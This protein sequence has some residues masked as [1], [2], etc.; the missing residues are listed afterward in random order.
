MQALHGA[1]GVGKTTLAVEYAHRFGEDYDVV[2]WVPAEDSTLIADRLADLA[3]T[4]GLAAA[5][6]PVPTALSRLLGELRHRERW[7]LIFDNAEDP[8]ALAPFLPGGAGHVLITSRDPGWRAVA[9]PQPIE[10]FDRA[11]SVDLLQSQVP[12]L[13]A[14][15]ADQLADAL[16]HLPLALAQAAAFMDETSTSAESYLHLLADRAQDMLARGVLARYPMPLAT[17]L[18]LAFD[19]LAADA[20]AALQLLALAAQLAPEPVPLTLFTAHAELLPDPLARVVADPLA[21]ADLI[22]LLRRRALARLGPDSFQ[23]THRLVATLL[24]TRAADSGIPDPR[25]V[26]ARLLRVAVPADPWNN[27]AVWPTWRLLLPHVLVLTDPARPVDGIEDDAWSM[28]DRAGTYLAA[29]GEPRTARPLHERAHHLA[30]QR[31]GDGDP[32]T[33]MSAHH[34]AMD[35]HMLG[36]YTAARDLDQDTLDRRRRE[37]GDDHPDT[38]RSANNLACDLQALGEYPAALPESLTRDTWTRTPLSGVGGC[39]ARTIPTP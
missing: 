14:G 16:G 6:D 19:R 1:G 31:F 30:E 11:E 23:V 33:L 26:A 8:A 12:G 28:L 37:L 36:Q 24:I 13:T 18:T 25:Q 17:S 32:R 27:P 4:L 15:A 3:R 10:V 35:L 20:P 21:M 29:R 22:G 5:T 7:L 34:L 39:S 9:Q 38:L 2:W